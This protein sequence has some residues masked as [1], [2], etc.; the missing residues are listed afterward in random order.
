[1]GRD[2]LAAG[3][4][5]RREKRPAARAAALEVPA[6]DQLRLN[7][8]LEDAEPQALFDIGYV[9]AAGQIYGFARVLA[10]VEEQ[11]WFTVAIEDDLPVERK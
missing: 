9:G 8:P 11:I 3:G 6:L 4:P 2:A 1:M 10:T 5:F 7:D